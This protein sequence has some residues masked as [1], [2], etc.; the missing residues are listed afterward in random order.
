MDVID[1]VYYL[2]DE[3]DKR[4][5][6]LC[7]FLEIRTSSMSTWK[8][9]HTDP[10]V[11]YLAKIAEFFHITADYLLTGKESS[12]SKQSGTCAETE[13]EKE[14]LYMYRKLP[15]PKRFEFKG[16]LKGYLRAVTETKKYVDDEKRLSV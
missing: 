4:A 8:T 5:V 3:Q 9:R 12:F 11:K 15:E 16:E 6:D 14:V 13:D 10:P 2:L 1:R 7:E